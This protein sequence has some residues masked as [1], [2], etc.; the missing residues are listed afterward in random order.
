LINDRRTI[1]V[2]YGTI[3]GLLEIRFIPTDEIIEINDLVVTSGLEE[4]I[5]SGLLIGQV[6]A[7]ELDQNTLFQTALL[8][9]LQDIRRLS[10]VLVLI[11]EPL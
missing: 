11:D 6:I 9:P 5:Q 10:Q 7:V 2:A 4:T 3:G 1:G 8:E